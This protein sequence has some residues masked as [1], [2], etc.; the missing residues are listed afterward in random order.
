MG[1]ETNLLI[2]LIY[3]AN[4]QTKQIFYAPEAK[5]NSKKNRVWNIKQPQHDL[6]EYVCDH[7]LLIH[8]ILGC[9]TVSHV[10]GLGKG[11]ALKRMK[12]AIFH[13]QSQVFNTSRSS[14]KEG[15][16]AIL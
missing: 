4:L 5:G 2:L 1:D 16:I 3:H 11:G 7:I 10:H 9:D 6:G 15:L 8:A 14:N 13:Q 12:N